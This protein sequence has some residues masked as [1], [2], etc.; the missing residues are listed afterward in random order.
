MLL[1]ENKNGGI[2]TCYF[3]SSNVL[4]CR[5]K[6]D[7]SQ[8]AIIFKGGTQYLY[9]KVSNYTFQRFKIAE[10]Q[11]VAFNRFIKSKFDYSKVAQDLDISGVLKIIEEAKK[12][13]K[14]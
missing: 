3:D 11:G 1:Q 9:E 7:T 5:Y 14:T 8:L 13:Q 10:S 4:A 6:F 12:N 2:S